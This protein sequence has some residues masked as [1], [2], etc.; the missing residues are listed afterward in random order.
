MA[1]NLSHAHL[2][3]RVY[4]HQRHVYDATRKYYLIG[5]DPMIAGLRPPPGGSVLEIGCGTGRNLVL[6]AKRYPDAAFFGID[7]SRQMLAT[8]AHAVERAGQR[9]RIR[10]ACADASRFDPVTTFGKTGFDRIFLS[11]AVSMIGEWRAVI[12]AAIE[13]LAPGGDL[14]IVDFGDCDGLPRWFKRGLYT[15]LRWYHVTPRPDLFLACRAMAAPSGAESEDI[16]LYRGF[17]W[18]AI[19]RRSPHEAPPERA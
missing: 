12:A 10:L 8:A 4:R 9:G 2:M 7:I 15:W 17:A 19:V 5:R 18:I 6:A 14:H 16:R 11:Y 13:H 1:A 3:D